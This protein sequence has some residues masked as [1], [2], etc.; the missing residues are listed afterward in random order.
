MAFNPESIALTKTYYLKG[1]LVVYIVA[2]TSLYVQVQSLFG[3]K[4]IVPLRD[5]FTPDDDSRRGPP[6]YSLLSLAPKLT[7][8]YGTFVEILCIL[9]VIVAFSSLLVRRFANAFS[10]ALLWYV[11]YSICQVGQG[12]MSFHSDLLL[13]EVGFITILVAPLLPSSRMSNS[14]HDHVAFFLIRWLTFRYFVTNVFNV[15]LD[16]DK[17]WYDMTAIPIVAQG[18]QFPS[19]FSWHIYNLPTEWVKIY[20]GYEHAVKLCAPFLFL[21]DLKYSRLLGFYTLVSFRFC[22]WLSLCVVNALIKDT[23]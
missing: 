15:Y 14:D 6:D 7:L 1:V 13:L 19:L 10:F 4:G 11:Y 16:N 21:F 8:N 20:Q 23:Y 3:E 12:F 2:F 22:H 9:G 5:F 18:V 17:A